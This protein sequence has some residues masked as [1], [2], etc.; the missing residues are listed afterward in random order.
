MARL[1]LNSS[2]ALLVIRE[3]GCQGGEGLGR[4]LLEALLIHIDEAVDHAT[5]F[6]AG[7]GGIQ[8]PLTQP[9]HFL[10]QVQFLSTFGFDDPH[11]A[12]RG[13]HDE[14]RGVRREI[15]I[16]FDIVQLS[17]WG[18]EAP[19]PD[20]YEWGPQIAEWVSV[21]AGRVR[22]QAHAITLTNARFTDPSNDSV[23]VTT[24]S[25]RIRCP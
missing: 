11:L 15:A 12:I 9:G 22:S 18:P 23:V 6:L 19:T 14:I 2:L 13:L 16:G 24:V 21:S 3:A 5:T 17:D 4:V 8:A 7:F 10:G 25:G 1:S 20:S